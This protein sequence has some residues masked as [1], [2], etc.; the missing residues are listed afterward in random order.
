MRP[1]PRGAASSVFERPEPV[2]AQ[3]KVLIFLRRQF[4]DQH[5]RFAFNQANQSNRPAGHYIG[6]EQLLAVHNVFIAFEPR[7]RAQCGQIAAGARFGERE[8]AK[9]RPIRQAGQE[10]LLLFRVAKRAHGIN[11]TDAA[12]N[13]GQ[14]RDGWIDERHARQE[15][16]KRT[17]RRAGAAVFFVD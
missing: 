6:D 8:R 3:L 12:V 10:T 1:S 17:E 11:R 5:G 4:D 7:S 16:R 14:S 2:L 9:A 15:R 13:R